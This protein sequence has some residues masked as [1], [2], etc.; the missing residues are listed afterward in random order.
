MSFPLCQM[1]AVVCMV[2]RA[3]LWLEFNYSESAS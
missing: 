1:F 3:L 2:I